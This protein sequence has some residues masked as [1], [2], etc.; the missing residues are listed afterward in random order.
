V[1]TAPKS[2]ASL[3][4]NGVKIMEGV[5]CAPLIAVAAEAQNFVKNS[6][7][8]IEKVLLVELI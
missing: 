2:V 1:G 6:E 5:L 3:I 7:F 8:F 4:P